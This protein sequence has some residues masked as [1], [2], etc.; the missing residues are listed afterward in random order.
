[1]YKPSSNG[2][3]TQLLNQLDYPYLLDN[4]SRENKF[5]LKNLC[6]YAISNV[7]AVH[8]PSRDY[9]TFW[10]SPEHRAHPIKRG[11]KGGRGRVWGYPD[12]SKLD[13][14]NQTIQM[15]SERCRGGW[16]S[17]EPRHWDAHRASQHFPD[18]GVCDSCT[19]GKKTRNAQKGQLAINCLY[20]AALPQHNS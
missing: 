15:P 8:F 14:P 12:P 6:F 13:S 11:F 3:Y 19:S 4:P 20:P 10:A 17:A 2:I 5:F 18:P 7:L 1:M 9:P 16:Q